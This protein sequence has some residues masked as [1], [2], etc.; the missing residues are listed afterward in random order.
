M[1]PFVVISIFE[2][3]TR[4]LSILV[5]LP[6]IVLFVFFVTGSMVK[7]SDDVMFIASVSKHEFRFSI[8]LL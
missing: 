3:R 4:C 8:K 2:R 7:R 5:F 6:L 1:K